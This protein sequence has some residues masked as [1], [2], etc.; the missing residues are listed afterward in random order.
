[1]AT[2]SFIKPSIAFPVLHPFYTLSVKETPSTWFIE[3]TAAVT[4]LN[5]KVLPETCPILA[6]HL[7]SI[8][9]CD[10]YNS[11]NTPFREELKH[12]E[13]GHL[14]EHVLLEYLCKEKLDAGHDKAEFIGKTSWNWVRET[15]G[16]F[17]IR[18]TKTDRKAPYFIQALKKSIGLLN[19]ILYCSSNRVTV[20]FAN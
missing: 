2:Q 4:C 20:G 6:K 3:M 18:I 8:F 12:T 16:K 7:P 14:F 1:M 11:E 15:R 17:H 19:L 5:T 10:C 9:Y 13:L